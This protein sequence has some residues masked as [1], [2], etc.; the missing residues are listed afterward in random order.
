MSTFMMDICKCTYIE[1]TALKVG[2]V[3][4][5][6]TPGLRERE[7]EWVRARKG[8]C[9]LDKQTQKNVTHRFYLLWWSKDINLLFALF[10]SQHIFLPLY[11]TTLVQAIICPPW[12]C[13]HRPVLV[14]FQ[15]CKCQILQRRFRTTNWK[16]H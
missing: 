5:E 8:R 4:M 13:H 12:A 7:R 15:K 3:P 6:T 11:K 9:V 1:N 16:L 14:N 2:L 10:Y